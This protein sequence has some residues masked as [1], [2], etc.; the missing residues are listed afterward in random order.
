MNQSTRGW[1]QAR[2]TQSNRR[3]RAKHV[4]KSRLPG[5]LV[6]S[7]GLAVL[8]A[9]VMWS[10]VS[11]DEGTSGLSRAPLTETTGGPSFTLVSTV[12]S[13]APVLRGSEVSGHRN[14]EV[15]TLET[16]PVT[17][18]RSEPGLVARQ[19]QASPPA[20]SQDRPLTAAP[21]PRS[22]SRKNTSRAPSEAGARSAE[23]P[24][25]RLPRYF[26]KIGVSPTQKLRIYSIQAK[27]H[28]R[29]QALARQLEELRG[30][31]RQEVLDVL[32]SLQERR[33]AEVIRMAEVAREARLRSRQ[34]GDVRPAQPMATPNRSKPPS[35][36]P[37]KP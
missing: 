5:V 29:F 16:T 3:K 4:P 18:L 17:I 32:T 24:R 20:R 26:G 8:G 25:G 30:Q 14:Q 35:R 21:K 1:G 22:K 15:T 13:D 33:L 10:I 28:G 7:L 23:K 36:D 34:K 19:A 27:Y 31:E 11:A 12:T 6:A 2:G 37:S 9:T